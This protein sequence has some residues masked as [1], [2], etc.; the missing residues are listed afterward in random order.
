[1]EFYAGHESMI[2]NYIYELQSSLYD[3]KNMIKELWHEDLLCIDKCLI[4]YN[5]YNLLLYGKKTH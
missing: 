3:R 4:N 2:K 5:V 1:M